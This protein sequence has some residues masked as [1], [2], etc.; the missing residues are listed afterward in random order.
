MCNE[1]VRF[2]EQ[3]FR[4]LPG[5]P[6]CLTLDARVDSQLSTGQVGGVD[7]LNRAEARILVGSNNP[8]NQDKENHVGDSR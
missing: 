6:V 2:F 5:V 7:L 8:R 1:A 3:R 4:R